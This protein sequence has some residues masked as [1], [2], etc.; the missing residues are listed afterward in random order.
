MFDVP[1]RIVE[2][3]SNK[4]SPFSKTMKRFVY[5]A[6]FEQIHTGSHPFDC[7]AEMLKANR[8]LEYVQVADPRYTYTD[9]DI[10]RTDFLGHHN[11]MLPVRLPLNCRLTFLSIFASSRR[12]R[13]GRRV[14]RAKRALPSPSPPTSSVLAE[15]PVERHV[16]SLIFDFAATRVLRRV[17]VKFD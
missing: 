11:Q 5:K 10:R 1:K 8:T 2:E 13:K 9:D 15:F 6:A 16:V 12:H 7:V 4:S 17:Y 14:T 3:L